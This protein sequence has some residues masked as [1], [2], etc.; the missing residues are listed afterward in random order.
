MTINAITTAEP[1]AASKSRDSMSDALS[2]VLPA[3]TKETPGG[4]DANTLRRALRKYALLPEGKRPTAPP[5][6][7]EAIRWLESASLDIQDLSETKV[8]RPAL[9]ALALCLDGTKAGANTVK[10]KR[11]VLHNVLEYAVELEELPSNPLHRVKWSP[12]KTTETVAPRVVVNPRRARE[13]LVA[14]TYGGK[15]GRGARGRGQHLMALF[16]CMYF[17]AL[18]PAEAVSLRKESRL[19]AVLEGLALR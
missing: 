18:R 12:P 8:I 16:A 4:P 11:A 10:R 2:T 1:H 17:A 14:A 15:R 3:L 9:D 6:M 5:D 7:A 19:R 13:L